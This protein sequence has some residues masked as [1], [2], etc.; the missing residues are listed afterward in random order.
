MGKQIPT[1]SFFLGVSSHCSAD[2]F[3]VEG[4]VPMTCDLGQK[5]FSSYSPVNRNCCH[6]Y[7]RLWINIGFPLCQFS[8]IWTAC[9]SNT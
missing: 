2:E 7:R 4:R 9:N 8:H 6:F 3:Y 5:Q 1:E